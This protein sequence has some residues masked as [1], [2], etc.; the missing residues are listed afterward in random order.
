MKDLN[1]FF[2]HTLLKPEATLDQLK[3]LCQEAKV[4]NFYSVCVNSSN[5]SRVNELLKDSEV[6][7]AAVVGFPLGACTTAT[8]VFETEDCCKNGASEIDMVLNI[9]RLK[10]KDYEF[11]K[12][13]IA[14]VVKAAAKY[15]AIVKVILETCLLTDVEVAIAS[16]LSLDVEA[17]FIK[18][19]TGFSTGGATLHHIKIMRDAVGSDMMIKASGGIRNYETVKQ[20]IDAGVDRIGASAT[21]AIMNEAKVK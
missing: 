19:S 8:K 14:A 2:D 10:E 6:K 20:F 18:T 3:K 5:V 9:G 13:D 21:V 4:Y 1:L 15:N 17:A 16:K 11:V 7:I 12:E